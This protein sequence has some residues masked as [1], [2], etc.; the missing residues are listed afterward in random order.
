MGEG[1]NSVIC[2]SLILFNSNKL[3]TSQH[4]SSQT[5][6]FNNNKK[7]KFLNLEHSYNLI[8]IYKF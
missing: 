8:L 7:N 1:S 3:L 5:N 4:K 6:F 2:N